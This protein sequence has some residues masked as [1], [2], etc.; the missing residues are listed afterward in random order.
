MSPRGYLN[1]YEAG[2]HAARS[3]RLTRAQKAAVRRR[4]RRSARRSGCATALL[5]LP[6]LLLRHR[7]GEQPDRHDPRPDR[8]GAHETTGFSDHL[9]PAAELIRRLNHPTTG[10]TKES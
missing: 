9:T 5:M 4:A 2:R 10:T 8:L 1:G 7:A 3:G 6:W